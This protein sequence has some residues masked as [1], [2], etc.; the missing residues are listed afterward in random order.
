MIPLA[1]FHKAERVMVIVDEIWKDVTLE[2]VKPSLYQVSNYGRVRNKIRN[3]IKS[4][5]LD[6]DGYHMTVLMCTHMYARPFRINRL[7]ANEFC[8]GRSEINNIVNHKDGDKSWDVASNLE[9]CTLQYNTIHGYIVSN[10]NK[11]ETHYKNK[12]PVKVIKEICSMLEKRESNAT[13]YNYITNKY[14][15]L[16]IT[17]DLVKDIKRGKTW[18]SVSINYN[19]NSNRINDYRKLENRTDRNI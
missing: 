3:K 16:N 9:R 5:S 12:Y 8:E 1:E 13:I 11:G 14:P 15:S 6:K 10:D 18:K 17:K 2:G 7:V 4:Q 19:I